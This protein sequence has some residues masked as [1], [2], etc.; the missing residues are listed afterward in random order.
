[1][2]GGIKQ[3]KFTKSVLA[4]QENTFQPKATTGNSLVIL[5]SQGRTVGNGAKQKF[6]ELSS[7][8]AMF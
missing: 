6:N 1:M 4:Y 5:S 2:A 8:K 7:K 3:E